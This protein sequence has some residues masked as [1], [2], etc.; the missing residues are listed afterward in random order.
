M[1]RPIRTVLR[2][3]SGNF[4]EMYDFMIFGYY[5]TFIAHTF[6]PNSNEYASLMLTLAT[7]GAGFLMRPIG[8]IILGLYID[9]HG[10]RKGLLLT[11]AL[12][13]VGTLAVAFM[14][15]YAKI[16]IVAPIFILIARLIQ[17]FSA[18]VELGGVSVY[19]SEI[20]TPG[21][22]GFYVAWQSAS[23]QIAVV[24][25]ATLGVL[26][27]AF[28]PEPDLEAWGWRIPLV[29]GCLIIPFLFRIRSS[30]KETNAFLERKHR[31]SIHELFQSILQNKKIVFLGML[32]ATMSTVTFYMI[33]AYTPTFG[34]SVLHLA[35]IDN[36]TVTLGVGVSNFFWLLI[37][38]RLS[39]RIG[40]RPI[41]F[42]CS[43]LS[44]LTAYPALHWLAASPTFLKLLGVELWLSF[45]YAGYNG[46]VIVY[47]TE[48]MPEDV[49]TTG[50]SLA[51][52]L[53][54]A[55]FG[56]FTPAICT[57]LIHTTHDS[58][59]PGFWLMF[60]AVCGLSAT[61]ATR[62]HSHPTPED[63]SRH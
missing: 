43:I 60:A 53:A 36:F 25:A 41:L 38:A 49:R 30:L 47:L 19:L 12:M 10:R 17:G 2:V 52:S 46:A 5:A 26:L 63:F 61:I 7:F 35:S 39:D 31:P 11:L 15:G 34:G 44:L 42:V 50:F 59:A 28:L 40:R 56:G 23:Q 21:K 16:G 62:S 6:F 20:A 37:I 45:L 3:A 18:G 1:A 9:H 51:Y 33:T 14:P 8:A 4:L 29:V 57:Y 48:L 27:H 24:F 55:L 22:K 58:A 54:T 32:L 13:S